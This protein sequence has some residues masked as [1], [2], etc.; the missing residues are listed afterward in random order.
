MKIEASN[1]PTVPAPAS[2]SAQVVEV[3]DASRWL[4]ISGQIGVTPDGKLAGD[5]RAQVRQCFANIIAVLHAKDMKLE[6]LLKITVFLTDANDMPAFRE[7]RDEMLAGHLCASTL[8]VISALARPELVV[9]IE[10]TAA[11]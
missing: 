7:V 11:S 6:N 5:A 10:A 1:P 9:E 2:H 8:L 4:E 3:R